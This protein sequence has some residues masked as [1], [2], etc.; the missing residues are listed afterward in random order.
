MNIIK[1][2]AI[3]STNSYLK[4]L[5][6][7]STLDTFTVI[8]ANHQN[9]GRGQLGTTWVSEDGKNLTFSILIGFMSG[10]IIGLTFIEQYYFA[11]VIGF[12]IILMVEN[13]RKPIGISMV[14]DNTDDK[15]MATILSVESQ[16]KS[17]FAAV[18]APVLGFIADYYSPGISILIVSA[19]LI[20]ISLFFRPKN[21]N[22][23]PQ[24]N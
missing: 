5:A 11:S 4:E 2:N 7:K 17:L 23:Q 15:A 12:V 18:I 10:V 6:Q 24:Y 22:T 8:V 21:K 9:S 20:L 1:L 19:I 14:A 3:D 16:T 13:I